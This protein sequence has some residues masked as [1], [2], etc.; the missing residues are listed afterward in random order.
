VAESKEKHYVWDPMTKFDYNLA[1][2]PLQI[3]PQHIYYEQHY[4]KVYVKG[5][6]AW[7]GFLS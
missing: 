1:L 6:V 7:D 4:A 5:T 2:Y 3:R